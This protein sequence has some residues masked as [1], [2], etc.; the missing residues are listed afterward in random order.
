MMKMNVRNMICSITMVI[1]MLFMIFVENICD[2][3]ARDEYSEKYL[4]ECTITE[5]DQYNENMG[6]SFVYPIGQHVNSR[7][8]VDVNGVSYEHGIEAW[9]ARWNYTSEKSWA[10]STFDLGGFSGNLV[11]KCVLID[12]YNTTNF[13]ST[14]YFYGDGQL[15]KSYSLKPDIIP[16]SIEL[17]LEKVKEL[18]I[19][20]ADNGY[21]EGGT[22]FGFTG[23]KLIAEDMEPQIESDADGIRTLHALIINGIEGEAGYGCDNDAA[24]MYDRIYKNKLSDCVIQ[25]TNIHQF[26]YNNDSKPVSV[27][28][29]NS[30]I[31]DSF[32]N[33]DDDDLSLF[34]Y[35]GHSTWNGKSAEEYGITLGKEFYK[36]D[37][38]AKYLVDNIKGDIVIIMDSCFAENFI[39]TGMEELSEYER[40]R[41]SVLT[42]C[43][44]REKS[45]VK[46]F[47]NVFYHFLQY[48]TFT[49]YIGEA[50]GFVDDNLKADVDGDNRV[51]LIE[52]YN[53]VNSKVDKETNGKMNVKL[54][55]NN[56]DMNLFE[57][58]TTQKTTYENIMEYVSY[59]KEWLQNLIDV[60]REKIHE[61]DGIGGV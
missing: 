2:S 29:I 8:N 35:T 60:I 20:V 23:M 37:K 31:S 33:T 56:K 49:Y 44:E 54:Y 12:S 40:N 26:S 48:G 52:L 30:K 50:L 32:A 18:K 53:F 16:F 36:W 46:V 15:L 9:I 59:C 27:N 47:Y 45:R 6:D 7:G 11:G 24:L 38:L 42:S 55:T 10:T 14:V 61:Q 17:E 58:N 5:Y 43:G 41:I 28:D 13:D 22:S 57:Y 4:D 21:F 25:D 51:S 1:V 19:Y 3:Y 39:T 34:Y